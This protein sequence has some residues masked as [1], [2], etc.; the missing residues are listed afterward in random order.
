M[1]EESLEISNQT[2]IK[3]SNLEKFKQIDSEQ[4]EKILNLTNKKPIFTPKINRRKLSYS[5]IEFSSNQNYVEGSLTQNIGSP[6]RNSLVKN[7]CSFLENRIQN[8]INS[9]IKNNSY[10]KN[11]LISLDSK[12][13][14]SSTDIWI[15]DINAKISLNS[16]D[17]SIKCE[18]FDGIIFFYFFNSI[19]F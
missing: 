7:I 3:C 2:Q 10:K 12:G 18:E 11:E 13:E 16:I 8:N 4:F 9:E 1:S 5:K 14:S 17:Y 19:F 6:N 15:N